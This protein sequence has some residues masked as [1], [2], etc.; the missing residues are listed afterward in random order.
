MIDKYDQADFTEE[1]SRL[2][3]D[4]DQ[5]VRTA[6]IDYLYHRADEENKPAVLQKFLD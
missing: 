5:Q 3:H 1:A 4:P 2:V 6:A